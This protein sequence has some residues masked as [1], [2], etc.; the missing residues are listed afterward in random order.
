MLVEYCPTCAEVVFGHRR[1]VVLLAKQTAS[2]HDLGRRGFEVNEL[3]SDG[4]GVLKPAVP[5]SKPGLFGLS[6][7]PNE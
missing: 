1:D 5:Q 2:D 3:A 6:D 4:S 7:A